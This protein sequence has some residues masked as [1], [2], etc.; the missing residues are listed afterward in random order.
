[1][2]GM[3]TKTFTTLYVEKQRKNLE[4]FLLL[5]IQDYDFLK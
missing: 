4:L 3:K 5:F 2:F 1:M